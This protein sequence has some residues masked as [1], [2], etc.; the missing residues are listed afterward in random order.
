VLYIEEEKAIKAWNF[1]TL[2]LLELVKSMEAINTSTLNEWR[3]ILLATEAHPVPYIARYRSSE[4]IGR[5]LLVKWWKYDPGTAW[6][7]ERIGT[8]LA[9]AV[10]R[11]ER[12]DLK[13]FER[14]ITGCS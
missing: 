10:K 6:W 9:N 1:L 8:Y 14:A 5:A 13:D 7:Y 4:I 11:G 12:G 2:K 3:E